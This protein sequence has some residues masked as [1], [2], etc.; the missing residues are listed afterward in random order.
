MNTKTASITM[1]AL[2]AIG[3]FGAKA[4]A[5]QID[6]RF[7]FSRGHREIREV[8]EY[9]TREIT[10]YETREVTEYQERQVTVYEDRQVTERQPRTR[11]VLVGYEWDVCCRDYRPVYRT[12]TCYVDV[13][14]C[15]RVPVTRCER[16]PV[17]RCVQVPVTRCVQVPVT[18]CA[19]DPIYRTG[20]GDERGRAPGA[21]IRWAW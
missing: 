7:G 11:T 1:A 17:T 21:R 8:T 19:P 14:V 10:E 20:C 9:E 6:F 2:A 3:A 16:V 12:E 18:R 13:V 15:R 5:Q 4:D